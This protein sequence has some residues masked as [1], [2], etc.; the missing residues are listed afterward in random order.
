M[1]SSSWEDF[2]RYWR[3]TCTLFEV[4]TSPR[5]LRANVDLARNGNFFH[6]LPEALDV[7]GRRYIIMGPWAIEV[8]ASNESGHIPWFDRCHC[9]NWCI[10]IQEYADYGC[11]IFAAWCD[12]SLPT[13]FDVSSRTLD[14]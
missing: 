11:N 1:N 2:D 7:H 5:S 3:R 8:K 12:M 14:V 10:T 13:A 4:D 9:R 6:Q